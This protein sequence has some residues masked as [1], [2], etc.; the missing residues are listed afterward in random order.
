MERASLA[1]TPRNTVRPPSPARSV[2]DY[3][4]LRIEQSLPLLELHKLALLATE[5]G[6]SPRTSVCAV[7][8]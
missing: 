1:T 8:P 4:K 6:P 2:L 5:G 3:E 7:W